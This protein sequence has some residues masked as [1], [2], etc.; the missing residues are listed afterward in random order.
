[1]K[2]KFWNALELGVAKAKS[3]DNSI[4]YVF[5][6][7]AVSIIFTAYLYSSELAKLN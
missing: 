5:I 1:M 2:G 3:N 7:L 6:I 4:K